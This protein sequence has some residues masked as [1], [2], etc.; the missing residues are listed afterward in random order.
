MRDN[1]RAVADNLVAAHAD[2]RAPR[3]EVEHG[4]APTRPRANARTGAFLS[5]GVDALAVLRAN[6]LAYPLDHPRSIRDGF[7]AFGLYGFD[8]TEAGPVPERLDAWADLRSRL[9]GLAER[10]SFTLVPVYTNVRTFSP[11]YLTWSRALFSPMTAAIVH[12]FAGRVSTALLGSDGVGI[13][14]DDVSES[15][16]LSQCFSSAALEV[17]LDLVHLDRLARI[18]MLA[19]WAD[20]RALMQ[21][22]HWVELPRP[23]QVN[24]GR[25][26][27]CVRTMLGLVVL[28]RLG[29][30]PAFADDDLTADRIDALHIASSNKLR[31]LSAFVGPLRAAG[32]RDL[33]RAIR[34]R[35]RRWRRKGR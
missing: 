10:E 15:Q 22:C 30:T 24:C 17:R 5:G 1:A 9:A 27:K 35:E 2:L 4:F 19:D 13:E 25:C 26:E 18:R 6:R 31:H 23:G 32:R 14:P 21:P 16:M 33:V 28:G 20:G 34:R 29:D 8:A 11:D 3:L 12:G 7:L